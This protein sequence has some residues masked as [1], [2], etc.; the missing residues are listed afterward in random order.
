MQEMSQVA[1]KTML[2]ALDGRGAHVSTAGALVGL[3]WQQAGQRPGGSPNNVFQILN[4]MIYWQDFC[5]RHLRG[6]PTPGPAHAPEGWPGPEAP[7]DAAEWESAVARF[8]AGLEEAK[9]FAGAGDLGER[10]PEWKDGTRYT[11][12]R[13]IASHN[14]YHIGQITLLRRMLGAWPPPGGGA[15]W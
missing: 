10:L 14:D 13:I 2:Q 1:E 9:H 7:A 4:H 8:G 15:T 12:L 6:N 11:A 3:D 5:L